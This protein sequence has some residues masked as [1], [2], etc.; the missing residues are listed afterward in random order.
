MARLL[1][2]LTASC[3][4]ELRSPVTPASRRIRWH[5]VWALARTSRRILIRPRPV[6][7]APE[8]CLPLSLACT[9]KV[10]EACGWKTIFL[11]PHPA[12]KS[13]ARIR[14]IFVCE[15]MATPSAR[16]ETDSMKDDLAKAILSQIREDELVAMCCDVVNI[17]SPTGEE[18]EMGRYMR[19]ALEETGLAISWQ[20]V[21]EGRANV[22]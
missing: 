12:A 11:L 16:G 14:M 18:L 6:R 20:E 7:C 1:A 3:E 8:W 15:G 22:V 13:F 9:G 10:A 21:E 5:M 2:T 4:R 19:R 17:P